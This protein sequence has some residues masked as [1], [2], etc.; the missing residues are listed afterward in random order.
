M[1]ESYRKNFLNERA[2]IYE[3]KEYGKDS[4]YSLMW[5]IEKLF[6]I[7]FFKK[8]KIN[9]YLDFA[10]GNGRVIEFAEKYVDESTGVDVS[11]D[12][13]DIA[14]EKVKKS[15]LINQD[16]TKKELK[17]KYDLITAFRFFLNAEENLRKEVLKEFKKI[18]EPKGYIIISN[19]GNTYSFR[20]F[21][22]LICNNI[23]GKNLN[24]IS[25]KE[26]ENLFN[27][28]GFKL[29]N[30][31]GVGFVPKVVYNVPFL[32][33]IFFKLDKILYKIKFLSNFSHNQIL[34]FKWINE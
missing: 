15:K 17:K 6:L 34:V 32:R 24:Q 27:K 2:K 13:L 26:L 3:N 22:Y 12:M 9:N 19:Q 30:Y 28:Y 10:T 31:R 21:T 14:E 33:K 29:I 5:D 23:F 11:P 4:Y 25:K 20:Y 7:N 18:L 1:V 8:H 16:I